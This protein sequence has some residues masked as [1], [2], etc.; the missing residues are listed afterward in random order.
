MTASALVPRRRAGFSIERTLPLII[1]VL[2]A[3]VL[4]AALAVTYTEVSRSA[5]TAAVDRLRR[6]TRELATTIESSTAQL[7]DRYYRLGNDSTVRRALT[8]SAV[9]P[10]A[11][12]A[13][14]LALSTPGDTTLRVQLWSADG[15]EIAPLALT[16]SPNTGTE[17]TG[18]VPER[19]DSARFGPFHLVEHGLTAFWI[20][21]PVFFSGRRLG[22]V[23]Q[24]R[25]LGTNAA[26]IHQIE[27]FLGGGTALYFHNDTGSF[28]TTVVGKAVSAPQA[29]WNNN[30]VVNRMHPA[31]ASG[32]VYAADAAIRGT[33]W[34]LSLELPADF[35][36]EGPR[37]AFVRLS[38]FSFVLLL[39]GVAVA[40]LISRRLTRPLVEVT[41]AAESMARGD[42]NYRIDEARASRRDEVGR[43]AAT[44]NRMANE[45]ESSRAALEQEVEESDRAR[46]EA[47]EANRTKSAFL[48][49]MSHELRT[50]LNAI[51]G[52]AELLELGIH[53]P[54]TEDQRH[55]LGRI[56]RSQRTLL[57]LIEDVL[58]FARIEAGRVEYRF[59]DVALD[60]VLHNVETM[61]EPQ[62]TAKGI[63]CTYEARGADLHVW[64]DPDKLA[65]VLTNLLAN[66]IKF[67]DRGGRVSVHSERRG[68]QVL[69]HVSDTGRGIPRDKLEHIFRPFTQ[70]D[71][72]LTRTAEGT[73][74]GLSI[75]RE[76]ARAMG[77]DLTVESTERV[78]STFTLRLHT[79]APAQSVQRESSTRTAA[80]HAS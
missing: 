8:G 40:W 10:R 38:A 29:T 30:G 49:T 45:V 71:S 56:R 26:A 44:F 54:I 1:T 72:G 35:V 24:R 9:D 34:V 60:D 39:L 58:S 37:A 69:V 78:G 77:G 73:G 2:L 31:T 17:A 47:D 53:G 68:N 11:L 36:T 22:W 23:A 15:R 80:T 21:S 41:V 61:I 64:A 43:L 48:A 7:K 20:T 59:T 76:F 14:F 16:V 33:P 65:Q 25:I 19:A 18:V 63:T 74:L 66:G 3:A 75:S 46:R 51:A 27:N 55:V 5:R 32:A 12:R 4:V 28:W 6:V 79:E 57:S 62:A 42:Y 67:T 13:S 50:P 70:A 52:Y